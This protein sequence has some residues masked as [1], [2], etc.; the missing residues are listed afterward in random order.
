MPTPGPQVFDE[1]T[2][3]MVYAAA[4]ADPAGGATVDSQSRTTIAAILVALRA[5]GIIAQD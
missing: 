1:D 3:T 4:I 2:S 5:A